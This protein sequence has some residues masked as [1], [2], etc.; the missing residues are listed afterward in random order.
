MGSFTALGMPPQVL[1]DLVAT[2]RS[3]TDGTLAAN[4]LTADID[5]DALDVAA[6]VVNVV[7]F[8]WSEPDPALVDLVHERGAKVSWQVGSVD[9][10][11]AAAR[12]GCDVVVV[13]GAEAGGHVRGTS[14]LL[15]L[16]AR[17][18][19]AVDVPVLAAGGIADARSFAAV[20][21]AGASGARIGTRFLATPESGAHPSY[22][23]AVVAADFASTEITDQF[24]I[25]PLCATLPR[26]RVLSDCVRAVE[27]L[28]TTVAGTMQL[29]GQTIELPKGHGLPPSLTAT[30]HIDAMAMYAGE[31]VALIHD[32]RP[33]REIVEDL[34]TGAERLLAATAR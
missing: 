24:A 1:G 10:A 27:R 31:S 5:R 11:V 30:G 19:D 9:A 21:T 15:P 2:L 22:K 34:V 33:A 32:I 4:F 12:A 25:C 13:Q 29:G 23:D 16:L 7:D 26:V 14:S 6:Q 20:L 28:D 3:R 8:F 17:T 18:L